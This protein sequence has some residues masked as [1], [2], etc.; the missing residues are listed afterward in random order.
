MIVIVIVGI[1]SAV[2]LPNFLNQTAKAKATECT[3]KGGALMGEIAA[4]ALNDN[5]AA[6][7]LLT[8]ATTGTIAVAN[9]NSS[10]CTFSTSLAAAPSNGIYTLQAIG[11]VGSEI[12]GKY[13]GKF[14]VNYETGKKGQ[15][16]STDSS[17][18][19]KITAAA[20]PTC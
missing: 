14:C 6:F 3:S 7:T 10:L 17:T 18:A 12:E 9:T 5:A 19:A 4:E 13:V 20:A 8:T 11:K 16:T 2:A 1:L 15:K